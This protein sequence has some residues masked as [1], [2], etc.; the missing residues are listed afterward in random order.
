MKKPE[1]TQFNGKALLKGKTCVVTGGALGIGRQISYTFAEGEA[2]VII[3]DHNQAAAEETKNLLLDTFEHGRVHVVPGDVSNR[4]RLKK[5][6]AEV[7]SI[8]G[9]SI[10]VFVNNAG[11]IQP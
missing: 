10:D 6:F 5:S 9:G 8:S 7:A 4:S 2:E 1:P 11:I 3:L